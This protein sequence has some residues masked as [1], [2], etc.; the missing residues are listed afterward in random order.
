MKLHRHADGEGHDTTG[1]VGIVWRNRPGL[2]AKVV[3][4]LGPYHIHMVYTMKSRTRR[5][6]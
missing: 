2:K 1:G 3:V 4:W 6:Q 5:K